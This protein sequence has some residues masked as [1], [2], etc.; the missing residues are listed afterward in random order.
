MVPCTCPAP[1]L[2]LAVRLHLPMRDGVFFL[3][4]C[5]PSPA[6]D[7]LWYP[8]HARAHAPGAFLGLAPVA[9][10]PHPLG[11]PGY[12]VLRPGACVC[13]YSLER[14]GDSSLAKPPETPL[15]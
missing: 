8:D 9:E 1:F 13:A 14:S 6:L 12:I 2:L 4:R 11:Q 7:S 15:A 10:Q 3:L 5:P